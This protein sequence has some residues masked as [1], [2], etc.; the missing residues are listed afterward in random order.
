MAASLNKVQ[1]IGHLGADPEIRHTQNGNSIANL[2]MATS[3]SWK[4][5]NSG[6]KREKTEWHRIVIF[7]ERLAEVA[8]KYLRKGAKVY[9]EGQLQTRKW[10]D[11]QGVDHYSTE[12]VLQAF[13]GQIIMLDSGKGQG[14]TGRR[15]PGDEDDYGYSD[16]GYRPKA[17]GGHAFDLNDEIPF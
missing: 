16:G 1:L 8:E 9:I 2:R 4:D 12:V 15:E 17:S 11:Q 3:E 14:G 10:T 6:E 13:N 5:R 7:N